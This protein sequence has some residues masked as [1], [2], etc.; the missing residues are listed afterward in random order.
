MQCCSF[1]QIFLATD[2]NDN[3]HWTTRSI[4]VS[5][6]SFNNCENG[7]ISLKCLVSGTATMATTRSVC[8]PTDVMISSHALSDASVDV[9]ICC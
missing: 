7:S 1:V 3:F 2:I 8:V 5:T 6:T 4:N 9:H